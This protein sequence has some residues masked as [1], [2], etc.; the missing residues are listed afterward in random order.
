MDGRGLFP[1]FM[2][3]HFLIKV[4]NWCT[5]SH[6]NEGKYVNDMVKCVNIYVTLVYLKLVVSIPNTCLT[7]ELLGYSSDMC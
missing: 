7:W 4:K 1:I 3:L 6:L 5:K 2:T